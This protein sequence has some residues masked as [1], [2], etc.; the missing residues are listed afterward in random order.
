MKAL[1]EHKTN[2]QKIINTN[3]YMKIMCQEQSIKFQQQIIDN[4]KNKIK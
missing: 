1:S 3:N 4:K 2:Q